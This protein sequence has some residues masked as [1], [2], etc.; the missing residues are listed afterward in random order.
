MG[1]VS[2]GIPK[3]EAEFLKNAMHLDTFIEGGTY[4]GN[5]SLYASNIF[6]KVFTIEYS[7]VVFEKASIILK[8]VPNIKIFEGD[9]RDH[10][11]KLSAENDNIL[12]WLDSHWSGGETY[13]EE[14]EC[15][16]IE[17]LNII[18]KNK[19]NC[20][21]LIDDARFFLS[22][23]PSPH[24][25]SSWP[26]IKDIVENIPNDYHVMVYDDVVYLVPS[27]YATAFWEFVQQKKTEKAKK[28]FGNTWFMRKY[29]KVIQYLKHTKVAEGIKKILRK[30]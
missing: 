1:A 22:P 28:E 25:I 23:P 15:P 27:K 20:A 14:D 8:D 11:K 7:H 12:Y 30:R 10:F 13:G 21:V 17:E 24:K 29:R 5:T 2:F 9:T 16:L 3:E 26:S 18:F 6:K 19:K 4:Y